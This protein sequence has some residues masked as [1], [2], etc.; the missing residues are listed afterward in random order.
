SIFNNSRI[1]ILLISNNHINN[2]FRNSCE[3]SIVGS[4]D[5]VFAVAGEEV[6]LPC[7]VKPNTSV[8]DMRV[9]WFRLHLKDSQVHLYDDHED[10]NT[11]QSQSYRGRT[12]LNHQA[13]QR[14]DASLKLSSVRVFSLV[15]ISF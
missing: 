9:E 10:K 6:I 13:L 3:H 1:N 12:K 4:A 5:P 2:L 7:S 14:G 15:L 11:D 8:V